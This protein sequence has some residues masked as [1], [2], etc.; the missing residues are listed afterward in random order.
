M[1]LKRRPYTAHKKFTPNGFGRY[2]Y[3]R[4][5]APNRLGTALGGSPT[6]A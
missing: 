2:F 6:I 5:E 3:A 1:H 4:P